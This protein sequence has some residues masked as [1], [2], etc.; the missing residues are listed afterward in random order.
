MN[1]RRP[2]DTRRVSDC[3]DPEGR[4]VSNDQRGVAR[5]RRSACDI[6]AFELVPFVYYLPAM[7]REGA[8]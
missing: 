2:L 8:F 5:P 4:P 6:G 1:P 7:L 3:T